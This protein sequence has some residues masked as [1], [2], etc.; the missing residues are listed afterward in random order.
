VLIL[1][2]VL[3]A[4]ALAAALA[5]AITGGT[6]FSLGN[7]AVSVHHVGAL[8][9]VVY[10][11]GA[12]R[13]TLKRA[14]PF[15]LIPRFGLARIENDTASFLARSL[16]RLGELS[17]RDARVIVSALAGA[18]LLVKLTNAWIHPGFFLGDDV[19]IHEMTFARLFNLDWRAWDLRS[20]F[21]P[22]TFIYPV[23]ALLVRM[24]VTGTHE[25]VFAG[26]AVVAILSTLTVPLAF[27]IAR[28]AYG[29][30]TALLASAFVAMSVLLV[31]YG[32]TELPR[33]IAAVFM[34]AA[35]GLIARAPRP[36]RGALSL[37]K[38]GGTGAAAMAGVALGLGASLRFS[39]WM[40][41]VPLAVQLVIE[42]RFRDLVVAIVCAVVAGG[43]V[44]ALSDFLYWGHPWQSL[45]RILDF[46]LVQRQSSRGFE[47]PWLYVVSATSWVDLF[48]LALA[49]YASRREWRLALW[50]WIPLVLLSLLPHKEARYLIPMFPFVALL[51]AK[52]SE[53]ATSDPH[54]WKTPP[55]P[56]RGGQ[57][58]LLL[59]AGA[60][61]ALLFNVA[62]FHV[63]RS[64]EGA[65]IAAALDST[66]QVQSI[67]IDQAWRLG[68]RL[69]L[70]H[71]P[72]VTD[73]DRG[74]FQEP[75]YLS[76]E[77]ART[78]ADWVFID[79]DLC[80]AIGCATTLG[81]LGYGARQDA[82]GVTVSEFAAF[83]RR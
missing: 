21:Y 17:P 82:A 24:G 26:R 37:S 78:H 9:A 43:S 56:F 27:V 5:V 47:P 58:P 12:V 59:V 48:T 57:I 66:G 13:L 15:L 49:I 4:A 50:A 44:Q 34:L 60:C 42:R 29:Q 55:T 25:L 77:L 76:G 3:I 7:T 28:R 75:G 38:G 35:Y 53:V 65:R 36:A 1:L 51:A 14:T 80:R 67:A 30:A 74:R 33:P 10:V 81:G 72:V 31:S 46:T 8:L 61:G 39:E 71:V 52:G 63:R 20:A 79:A 83:S 11:L 64:D 54:L 32:G 18:V 23:Q 22:M 45:G 69:Y 62:G 16:R 41:V 19:E 2:D 40:F 70:R 73:L 6:D 68:G